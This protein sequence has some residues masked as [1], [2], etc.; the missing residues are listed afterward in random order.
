[1]CGCVSVFFIK[2]SIHFFFC[3]TNIQIHSNLQKHNPPGASRRTRW[4]TSTPGRNQR[5]AWSQCL[6][7]VNWKGIKRDCKHCLA[8]D[9]KNPK[10]KKMNALISRLHTYGRNTKKDWSRSCLHRESQWEAVRLE[11][12]LRRMF[13]SQVAKP[14]RVKV[15]ISLKVE[16]KCLCNMFMKCCKEF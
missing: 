6:S 5:K 9:K 14:P 7:T 8:A 13:L 1:M 11:G 3:F 4:G 2:S 12:R 15:K 16:K 10:E